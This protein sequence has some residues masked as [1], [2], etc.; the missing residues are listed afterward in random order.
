DREDDRGRDDRARERPHAHLVDPGDVPD[1]DAPEERLQVRRR[2]R[3]PTAALPR[4]AP[5]YSH[6]RR[7]RSKRDVALSKSLV[8]TGAQLDQTEA[9]AERI[10]VRRDP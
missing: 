9:V 3:R 7:P 4:T 5:R 1:A 2:R 6:P 8:A 10:A